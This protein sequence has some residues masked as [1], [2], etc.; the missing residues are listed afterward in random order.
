MKKIIILGKGGHARSVADAIEQEGKYQI[1]GYVVNEEIVKKESDNYPIVGNDEDLL[2]LYTNGIH[3]A[4]IGIGYLGKGNLRRKLYEEL[5]KIGYFLP[6]ICDPSA[7]LSKR[8]EIDE[9]T[10]IGK[11]AVINAGAK[12]EKMCIIN[13]GAIIEHDCHVKEFSHVAV[14]TVLCGGVCIG[15]D[16]FVGANATVIQ[17]I[18]VGNGCIIGAGEVLRKDVSGGMIYHNNKTI[19]NIKNCGGGV[20]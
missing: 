5:K 6:V 12:V 3:Y 11:G 17:D 9:G 14:G 18:D 7:S 2:K 19:G 20:K 15:S 1:A 8:I 4:A 10:F 13:S 16:V